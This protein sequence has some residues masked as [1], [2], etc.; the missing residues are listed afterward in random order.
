[1]IDIKDLI[2]PTCLSDQIND[3]CLCKMSKTI[4]SP[5]CVF[6]LFIFWVITSTY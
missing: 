5:V 2:G 4:S 3:L 6:N 1:M